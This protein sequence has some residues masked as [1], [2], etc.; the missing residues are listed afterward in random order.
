[1]PDLQTALEPS[2]PVSVPAPV[3]APQPMNTGV[4]QVEDASPNTQVNDFIEVD[5]RRPTPQPAPAKPADTGKYQDLL[6]ANK[7][8]D[9]LYKLYTQG[10]ARTANTVEKLEKVLTDLPTQLAQ[11][12]AQQKPTVAPTAQAPQ[13]PAS[14]FKFTIDELADPDALAAS[15]ERQFSPLLGQNQN[16]LDPN[17]LVEGLAPKIGEIIQQQLAAREEAGL[18]S[19]AEADVKA[20]VDAGNDAGLVQAAVAYAINSDKNVSSVPQAWKIFQNKF[21][22]MFAA[23]KAEDIMGEM[24]GQRQQVPRDLGAG[25]NVVNADGLRNAFDGVRK[26][27]FAS[28]EFL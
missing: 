20:L 4:Q 23:Q 12:L 22:Q 6:A 5:G 27:K 24:A 28:Q 25:V 13:Q 9:E 19:R 21:P 1:M 8:Y 14:R 3:A 17:K 11:L 2:A 26:Y 7:G 10:A 18:R 16:Q 15:M